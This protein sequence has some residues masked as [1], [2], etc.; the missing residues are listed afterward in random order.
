MIDQL[1]NLGVDIDQG[2][3]EFDR[4]RRGEANAVYAFDTGDIL[5]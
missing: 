2:A 1:G 5:E 3:R 4:V